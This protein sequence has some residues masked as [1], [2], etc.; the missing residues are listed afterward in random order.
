MTATFALTA[1]DPGAAL[2]RDYMEEYSMFINKPHNDTIDLLNT[3]LLATMER[4]NFTTIEDFY[5]ALAIE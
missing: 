3:D 4:H 5:R 1:I 2:V